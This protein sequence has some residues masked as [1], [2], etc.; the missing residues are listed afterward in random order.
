MRL[1]LAFISAVALQASAPISD[2]LAFV[3]DVYKHF[4]AASPAGSAMYS[5]S[6]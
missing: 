5:L 2:P 3:S 4:A 6:F 1:S